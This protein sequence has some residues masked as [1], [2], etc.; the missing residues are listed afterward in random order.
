MPLRKQRSNLPIALLDFFA[1]RLPGEAKP[2]AEAMLGELGAVSSRWE[3]LVW[4]LSGSWGLSKIWLRA[5]LRIPRPEGAR[6]LPVTLISFY[7]ALFSCVILAVLI[8]QLPLIRTPW[9]EAFVPLLIAFF[10]AVI[11]GVIALGLWVLDDAARYMAI[12]FSFLHALGNYAWISSRHVPGKL[13]PVG[14]IVL[15]IAIIAFLLLPST[16]RAFRS[17]RTDLGLRN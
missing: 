10:A 4:A 11:P 17:T 15:D 9:Q 8:R 3:R 5:S 16:K 7:H 1:R 12:F 13:L 14:R 6:P 2:W